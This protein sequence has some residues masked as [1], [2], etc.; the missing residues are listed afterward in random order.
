M[1]FRLLIKIAAVLLPVAAISLLGETARII[2]I[3]PVLAASAITAYVMIT[4][5]RKEMEENQA[6]DFHRHVEEVDSYIKPMMA[7]LTQLILNNITTKSG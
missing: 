4:R 2:L 3:L 6:E 5:L 7:M 1:D